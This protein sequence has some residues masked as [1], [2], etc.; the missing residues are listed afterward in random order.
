[1]TKRLIDR[2]ALKAVINASHSFSGVSKVA[3]PIIT[4]FN[5]PRTN[6]SDLSRVIESDPDLSARVLKIANSGYYGLRQKIESVSRAVIMLGWNAIKMIALG[7]TI[8]SKMNEVNKQLY[9]HSLQTAMIARFL[10]T[11]ADFYKIEE[12][13]TVGLLHDVGKTILQVYF[14]ENYYRTIQYVKDKGVPY[15]IAER[16]ILG[17]D[18]AEI[19]GWTLEDWNLPKNI[20]SSVMWHHD[21]KPNTYHARKTAVVHIADVLSTAVNFVGPSWEKV[22]EMNPAAVETLGFSV[23]D[24]KDIVI[25]MSKMKVDPFII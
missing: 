6:F 11:E 21:F 15:H 7:S 18:H 12:I 3:V 20:S 2:E 8:L 22:P 17:I 24:F 23:S 5:D 13:S 1:M 9:E 10:A 4:M 14:P 16:E 19:G 25:A